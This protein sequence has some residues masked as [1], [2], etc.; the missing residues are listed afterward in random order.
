MINDNIADF[1][2]RLRNASLIGKKE[3]VVP[4]TNMIE[5]ITK[6]LLSERYLE[7]VT[8]RNDAKG[9]KEIVVRLQYVDAHPAINHITTISKPGVRIYRKFSEMHRVLSGL[10]IAVISTSKGIMSNK[11]A[12]AA[13]IGGEV[14]IELW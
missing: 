7:N 10:G 13:K 2:T 8:I 12:F 11:G 4:H 9:F 14:L 5:A 6:V 3:T 1:A